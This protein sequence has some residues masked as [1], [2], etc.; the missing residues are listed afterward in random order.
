MYYTIPPYPMSSKFTDFNCTG[1]T[2]SDYAL[3]RIVTIRYSADAERNEYQNGPGDGAA[4]DAG[5]D[6][7]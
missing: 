7:S 1:V 4:K 5:F 3:F 2:P 6:N